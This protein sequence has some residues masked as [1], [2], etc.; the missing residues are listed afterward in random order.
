MHAG[1]VHLDVHTE[2]SLVD[3]VVRVKPLVA[4]V[5]EAG[6]PAVAMTD[7]S[8]LFA[9]VRFYQAAM[10]AGIKP[11]AGVDLWVRNPE[12]ESQPDRLI[13]LV[14]DTQGYRNLTR[15]VSA[16]GGVDCPVRRSSGQCGQSHSGGQ[17]VVGGQSVATV[18]ADLW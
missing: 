6:M 16:C 15:L 2:Y 17:P 18:A 10:A 1:F 4:R 13:L 5:V 3:S 9:L 12:D 14:K 11:I 7:Q 8:N